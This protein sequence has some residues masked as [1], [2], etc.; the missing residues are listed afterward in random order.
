MFVKHVN[1]ST[2]LHDGEVGTT[3]NNNNDI[4]QTYT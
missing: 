1:F 4:L 3:N 2:N